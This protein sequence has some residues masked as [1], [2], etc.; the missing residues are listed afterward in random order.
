MGAPPPGRPAD[1]FYSAPV[2]LLVIADKTSTTTTYD[3]S[4]ALGNMMLKAHELGL[5]S[6]WIHRAREEFETD[7]YRQ[8]LADHGIE[9][10]WV[11]IGHCA[12]G[13]ADGEIPAPA[14]RKD[15]RVFY[16]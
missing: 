9:G 4:L 2:M 7:E 15:G 11:G 8:L 13:Y 10:E 6:C 1:P 14:P 16:L 12:V 5:A 3:G